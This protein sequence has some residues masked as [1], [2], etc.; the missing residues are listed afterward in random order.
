MVLT[1]IVGAS[2]RLIVESRGSGH[3]S[4]QRNP[5]LIQCP[6]FDGLFLYRLSELNFA[7]KHIKVDAVPA[8]ELAVSDDEADDYYLAKSFFDVKEYDR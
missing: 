8:Y 3:R 2:K 4:L 6:N 1:V 7:L 5:S